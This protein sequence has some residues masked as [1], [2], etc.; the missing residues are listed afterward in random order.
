MGQVCFPQVSHPPSSVPADFTHGKVGASALQL[1]WRGCPHGMG[2]MAPL[3][4]YRT[5]YSIS[6]FHHGTFPMEK[7]QGVAIVRIRPTHYG[8]LCPSRDFSHGKVASRFETYALRTTATTWVA[9][10]RIRPTHYGYL[11]PNMGRPRGATRSCWGTPT[12]DAPVG[13]L[14]HV[15]P[16]RSCCPTSIMLPH[17]DHVAPY[18]SGA[19]AL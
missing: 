10:V 2:P 8:H 16:H 12:W 3:L 4:P 7:S 9:I 11:C 13:Q 15:A 14:D 19:S 17:I 6:A 5:G 1:A 18:R